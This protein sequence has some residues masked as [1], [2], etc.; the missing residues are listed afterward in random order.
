MISFQHYE[1]DNHRKLHI[2]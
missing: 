2:F 1:M